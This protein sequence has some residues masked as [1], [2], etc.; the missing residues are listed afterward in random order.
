MSGQEAGPFGWFWS[1][2]KIKV[3]PDPPLFASGGLFKSF[4][5][6]NRHSGLPLIKKAIKQIRIT[7]EKQNFWLSPTERHTREEFLQQTVHP[8]NPNEL[9]RRNLLTTYILWPDCISYREAQQIGER[10]ARGFRRSLRRSFPDVPWCWARWFFLCFFPFSF[11]CISYHLPRGLAKWF[12]PQ[13]WKVGSASYPHNLVAS[14]MISLCIF[15]GKE[16]ITKK[17]FWNLVE[18]I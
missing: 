10:G 12:G 5:K 15:F 4:V 9:Q 2:V 11:F 13:T 16:K 14:I 8:D 17:L 3:I 1:F 6:R 18:G 7:W